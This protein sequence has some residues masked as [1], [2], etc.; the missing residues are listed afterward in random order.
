MSCQL[1]NDRR[2]QVVGISSSHWK[3]KLKDLIYCLCEF[4]R[5]NVNNIHFLFSETAK[6]KSTIKDT[7]GPATYHVQNGNF[8][9]NQ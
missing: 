4:R 2:K 8:G 9:T 1:R 5:E 3:T 6:E 7:R